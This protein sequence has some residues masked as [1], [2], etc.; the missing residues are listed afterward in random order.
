MRWKLELA[1]YSFDIKYRLGAEN[2][3]ADMLSRVSMSLST[4]QQ[5]ATRTT[6]ITLPSRRYPRGTL[7]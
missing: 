3:A 6:C 2:I 1:R 7:C 4:A 5:E